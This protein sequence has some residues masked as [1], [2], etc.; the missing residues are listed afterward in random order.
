MSQENETEVEYVKPKLYRRWFSFLIDAILT[1]LVGMILFSLSSFI[2]QKT[3]SY[4]S[5]VRERTEIQKSTSIYD[6]D[7]NLLILSVEKSKDPLETKKK[8]LSDAIESFYRDFSY[9]SDKNAYY[10]DYQNR[11]KEAKT[12]KGNPMFVYDGETM[13]YIEKAD[14]LVKDHYD[15]YYHEIDRYLVP[16]LSLNPRYRK[17]TIDL[18]LIF[19]LSLF[20]SVT[21][22][23]ILFFLVVPLILKRGHKTIG[24]YL[25]HLSFVS[26]EALN[27]TTGKFILR[28]V[29]EFFIGYLLSIFT[30]FLPLL[31]SL[32]M[33]H[34]SKTGQDFFDYVSNTYVVDTSKK[35]VYLDYSEFRSRQEQS[36]K[37]RIEDKDY[38]PS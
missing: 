21:I 6:Q 28:F 27:V 19:V 25:F 20:L 12:E 16:Y 13:T 29:L 23:F 15:F 31:V 38:R 2:F 33:M 18:F 1:L 30:F 7:G 8:T 22:S 11:K 17:I 14:V 34:L 36:R 3:P 4:V 37:T 24:M 9:F 10:Q 35:D 32:T 26:V 5:L